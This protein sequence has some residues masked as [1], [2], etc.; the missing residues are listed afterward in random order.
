[1]AGQETTT[2]FGKLEGA[3]LSAQDGI[4]QGW[5]WDR[6]AAGRTVEVEVYAGGI[7]LGCVSA[8]LRDPR[9]PGSVEG[10]HAF[11][12][13]VTTKA[14]TLV[15]P[16][17]IRARVRG[18]A[19]DLDGAIEV[20]TE[21]DHRQKLVAFEGEVTGI[22]GGAFEGWA[23]R[24]AD[25]ADLLTVEIF[26]KGERLG[27]ARAD[28]PTP[29]STQWGGG[30]GFR[31]PLP[32]ALLDGAVH[33]VSVRVAGTDFELSGSPTPVA[34][35]MMQNLFTRLDRLESDLRWGMDWM[36]GA[37]S[38]AT[39]AIVQLGGDF[40]RRFD[41]MLML[42]RNAFER[43]LSVMRNRLNLEE[44]GAPPEVKAPTSV[45]AI[46][47]DKI[48]GFGWH[49]VE[50]D[51]GVIFR[52]MAT[53]GV[54]ILDFHAARGARL[55]LLARH[56]LDEIHMQ[57][58]RV[59]VNGEAA[60]LQEWTRQD[61]FWRCEALVPASAFRGRTFAVVNLIVPFARQPANGDYRDLS[62][63]IA[64]VRLEERNA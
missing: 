44:P 4:V 64:E 18:T 15:A 30:R 3:L 46:M 39:E 57:T 10:A 54:V 55:T 11:K 25:L 59:L 42:Q 52:W 14:S 16:Y 37:E 17:A 32:Q 23:M 1:M 2:N 40:S 45:R 28:L 34:V 56:F 5:A 48:V 58:L 20:E 31:L 6:L 61:G 12:L 60:S 21:A 41:A 51:E 53:N 50:K 43:E 29:I 27:S 13:T 9:Q 8:N 36:R 19:V 26:V 47:D 22:S 62:V 49:G 7:L 35:M 38:R 63:G 24:R 33:N